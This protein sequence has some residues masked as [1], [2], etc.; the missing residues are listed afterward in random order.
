MRDVIQLL[1]QLVAAQARHQEVGIGHAD[2][3]VSARV[4]D[5][6]NLDPPVF[7]GADPNKDPQVFIDRVQRTL[8]DQES[9][10]D[11]VT[12]SLT[13]LTQKGAKFQWTDACER[14]FQALKDRLTS[15]LVV[16][17]A[18]RQLRKHEKNYP[19]HDLDLAVVIHALK[20]WRHYL[21]GAH[22]DFYMDHKSLQYIFK[23]KELNLRQRRWLEL[24]KDYD[25]DILYH[26]GKENV[27]ANALSRRSMGSMSYLQPEKMGI[28]HEVHQLASLGVWL[29]DSC[30]IGITLQNTA[31]SS[32]V[33]EV[34]ERQ[35]EDPML[36][37]YRD[38]ILQKEKTPFEITEYGVLGYQG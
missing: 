18:S 36:V 7:I 13:K 34:K 19:T 25:V 21:Y 4:R 31:T 26:P 16:A 1:T 23:Q 30:D 28:A 38:T 22:V 6:I 20:I 15:A 32:L 14:S 2:R 33:T 5:F 3:S 17:Y 11:V 24:L 8:R 35:Y 9:S 12:A 10:L 37:H 27:V 29:L